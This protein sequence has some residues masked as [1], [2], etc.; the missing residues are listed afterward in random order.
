[1][2]DIVV[3]RWLPMNWIKHG[4]VVYVSLAYVRELVT[5]GQAPVPVQYP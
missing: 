4:T 3:V 2:Y 1:M 5:V